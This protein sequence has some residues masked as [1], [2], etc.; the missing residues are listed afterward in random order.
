[1]NGILKFYGGT[2]DMINTISIDKLTRSSLLSIYGGPINVIPKNNQIHFVEPYFQV[3]ISP[4]KSALQDYS[5]GRTG[6]VEVRHDK[7]ILRSL[8]QKLVIT[9]K[10]EFTF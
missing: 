8:S 5:L 10:N 4:D 1:M 6:L 3:R 7:S 9:F 2:V